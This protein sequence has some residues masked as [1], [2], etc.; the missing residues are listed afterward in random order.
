MSLKKI[1]K[2]KILKKSLK[3]IN[4]ILILKWNVIIR[5]WKKNQKNYNTN[6]VSVHRSVLIVVFFLVLLVLIYILGLTSDF[7]NL[8]DGN[9][10][11]E[12][13]KINY[14]KNDPKN[15]LALIFITKWLLKRVQIEGDT[16]SL[17]RWINLPCLIK[18]SFR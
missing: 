18:I 4:Y 6:S 2:I 15:L 3:K 8:E 11:T 5:T 9:W 17:K 10:S 16:Y 1:K 13:S 12:R 14:Y 7:N